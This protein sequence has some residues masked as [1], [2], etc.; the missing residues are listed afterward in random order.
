MR[1]PLVFAVSLLA[2][3]GAGAQDI[4]RKGTPEGAIASSVEVSPNSRLVYIS[5]TVP[6]PAEPSAPA[7]SPA[8]FGD[9]RTQTV[10]VL[11]KI[12]TALKAHDLG[13]G[14][15]VMMRVF[16][17]APTGT[18]RMDFAGMMAGYRQFFG[19]AEQPNKPARATIE[20]AGL[21]DPD[22]LVEIEVTA[23]A[24]PR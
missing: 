2:A 1:Y 19:T 7:G 10:S 18:D 9:T 17:V 21:V 16:L 4:Q 20:V 24:A 22:W 5:G 11:R 14:D 13:L 3:S 8:R 23:A 12:E 15:V 6:D